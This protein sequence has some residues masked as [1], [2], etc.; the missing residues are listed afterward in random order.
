MIPIKN[1]NISTN[2]YKELLKI[3]KYYKEYQNKYYEEVKYSNNLIEKICDLEA[4]IDEAII[5]IENNKEFTPRLEDLL[6]I[7]EGNKWNEVE[8]S[9]LDDEPI[10]SDKE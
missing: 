5:Y 9:Y 1:P 2:R 7:L 10:G 3:E 8:R 4:K 6:E